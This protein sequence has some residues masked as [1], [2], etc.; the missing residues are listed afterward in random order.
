MPIVQSRYRGTTVYYHVHAELVRAS[1]YRGLTT[2]QDLAV[3]MALPLSGSHLGSETGHVLGEIAEDEVGA[4]RPMLSAV[5]VSVT[6]RP[7]PGFF[8]L[9]RDLGRLREGEG[10]QAFW[11]AE[12]RRVYEAWRRPLL[13]EPR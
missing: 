9:A 3:I 6:G 13:I 1:Q 8:A 12:C 7:G 2:Y 5:A 10:E 4:G 11:E